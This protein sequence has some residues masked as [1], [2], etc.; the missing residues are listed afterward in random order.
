MASPR[1]AQAVGPARGAVTV[2]DAVGNVS[3]SLRGSMGAQCAAGSCSPS[4]A[5]ARRAQARLTSPLDEASRYGLRLRES[6]K[7]KKK[8]RH[9]LCVL[10]NEGK[11]Q[12][13]GRGGCWAQVTRCS[14][15]ECHG[16]GCARGKP[17]G[18]PAWSPHSCAEQLRAVLCHLSSGD[19]DNLGPGMR[20]GWGPMVWPS[21]TAPSKTLPEPARQSALHLIALS[22]LSSLLM[23]ESLFNHLLFREG[24]AR[25]SMVSVHTV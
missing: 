14:A 15:V 19:G 17:G 21:G 18:T 1:A 16:A 8:K 25:T 7:K 2:R 10:G 11:Y 3:L 12:L 24:C 6:L 20:A 9:F 23:S 22:K 5:A 4:R 13:G